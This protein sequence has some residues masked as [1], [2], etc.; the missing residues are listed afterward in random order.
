LSRFVLDASVA[1]AWCF[2]DEAT[3]YTEALL[4]RLA[5]GDEAVVP[6]LWPYEVVNALLVAERRGRISE[7]KIAPFLDR[8]SGF[9]FL[10]ETSD[11]ARAFEQ[12]L[13]TGRQ[14]CLSGYDA[15]YLELAV[16][17]G[18]PLATLDSGLRKAARALG[19]AMA[20]VE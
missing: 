8:L 16:R 20:G 15:A 14:R 9:A 19:V 6:A 5:A 1:L 2:E 18:L 12:V 17:E 11:M 4:D 7:A 13:S 3:D 10:I